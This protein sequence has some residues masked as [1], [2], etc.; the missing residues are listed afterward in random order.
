MFN[1]NILNF[2]SE[3]KQT[4]FAPEYNYYIAEAFIKDINFKNL[5]NFLLKKKKKY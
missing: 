3:P 4:F 2:K 1:I 5:S